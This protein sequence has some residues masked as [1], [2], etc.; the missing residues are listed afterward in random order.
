M[1]KRENTAHYAA[2]SFFFFLHRPRTERATDH[3]NNIALCPL[4]G[5]SIEPSLSI[6]RPS[7]WVATIVTVAK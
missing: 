5:S 4:A 3:I 7:K 2:F 1:L 6:T